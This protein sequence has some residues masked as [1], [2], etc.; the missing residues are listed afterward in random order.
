MRHST[1]L[2]P[3]MDARATLACESC[4]LHLVAGIRSGTC[5]GGWDVCVCLLLGKEGFTMQA[6]VSR[7]REKSCRGTF[8]AISQKDPHEVLTI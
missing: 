4:A 8:F 5:R 6:S 2:L 7:R 1:T 3:T